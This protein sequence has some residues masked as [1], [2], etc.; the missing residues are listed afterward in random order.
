[1]ILNKISIKNCNKYNYNNII[2]NSILYFNKILHNYVYLIQCLVS[3]YA[4]ERGKRQGIRVNLSVQCHHE[5]QYS[6]SGWMLWPKVHG[7]VL[8]VFLY[9]H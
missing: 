2:N 6:V 7:Y 4:L 8:Y 9:F 3:I 1:M 5:T